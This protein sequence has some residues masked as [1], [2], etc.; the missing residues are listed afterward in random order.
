MPPTLQKGCPLSCGDLQT[1]IRARGRVS[2][3][4]ERRPMPR[5]CFPQCGIEQS[6][7]LASTRRSPELKTPKATF[8]RQLWPNQWIGDLIFWAFG[9]IM[10][11]VT[12]AILVLTCGLFRRDLFGS[13]TKMPLEQG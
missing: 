9:C 2:P 1:L 10:S 13:R 5:T 7:R 3:R 6:E 4:I 8:I 12:V 11:V